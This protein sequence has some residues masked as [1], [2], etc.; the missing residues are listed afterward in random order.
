VQFE[1]QPTH[2]KGKAFCRGEKQMNGSVASCS[3]PAQYGVDGN[4]GTSQKLYELIIVTTPLEYSCTSET[5]LL[6]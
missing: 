5:F 1:E 3:Y 4:N 2:L 6:D